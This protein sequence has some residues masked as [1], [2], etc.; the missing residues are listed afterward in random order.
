MKKIIIITTLSTLILLG[1]A[2]DNE[3][4]FNDLVKETQEQQK[5]MSREQK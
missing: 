3:N 2:D 1:C 5:E 4:S